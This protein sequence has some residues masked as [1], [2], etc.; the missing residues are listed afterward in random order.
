VFIVESYKKLSPDSSD[1]TTGLLN[2]IS[3]QLAGF[4]NN[5][6]P[7]PQD[8]ASFTPSTAILFVNA[9]WFLS[10]IIAIVSAFYVMLVQQWTRRYNQTL[11]ELS[12]NQ[13]PERVRSSLFLGAQKYRLLHAVGLIPLPLHVSVFLFFTGLI[14][15]LYTI[16]HAMA[17]VVTVAVV[18]IGLLYIALTILPITDDICPY[19]TPMSDA[20]WYVWHMYLSAAGFC[21]QWL[22]ARFR[23]RSGPYD[24]SLEGEVQSPR[25]DKLSKWS[26]ILESTMEKN[27]EHLKTGLRGNIFRH[28]RAV[29]ETVDL[30]ALTWL[31]QR[32]AM[33]FK[34]NFQ[35]FVE[36][37]PPQ[38]LIRLSSLDAESGEKTIRDHLSNLFRSC[39]GRTKLKEKERSGRLLICLNAFHHIVKPS[40]LLPDEDYETVIDDVWSNFKDIKLVQELWNNSDPAI[41]VTSRSVC[42][43]LARNLLR[44]PYSKLEASERRWL[45]EV[46]GKPGSATS[47][48]LVDLTESTR[49]HLNLQSFVFGVLSSKKDLSVEDGTRFAE[50]LAVLMNAGNS[51]ALSRE[52]FSEEMSSFIE[53]GEKGDNE[54]CDEVVAQLR[55]MFRDVFTETTP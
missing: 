43:H 47:D 54:H 31:L 32:P 19:F 53:W 1:T 24:P 9:V 5:T 52:I 41:R 21:F 20:A 49:D 36:T 45:Q 37:I 12:S 42:A 33:A 30:Q 38:T 29:P 28:A 8:L 17:I 23:G 22:L 3:Q 18:S 16:S 46:L 27:R 15:F 51:G 2:Q 7:P 34:S 50:T 26:E 25:T 4:Q 6:Y 14:V 48:P 10:L 55:E 35:V 13:E 39:I 11:A 40:I 44:K